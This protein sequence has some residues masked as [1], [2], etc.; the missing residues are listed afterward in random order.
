MPPALLQIAHGSRDPRHAATV[1]AL[2]REVRAQRPGLE[3]ATAYLDHCAPRLSQ[4]VARLDGPA[5]AVPLLLNRAY[6]AKHDIPAALRSAG[7]AGMP[8]ADVLGPAPLLLA[9]LERRLAQAGLDLAQRASTGVVLAAAGSSDPAADAAT[10]AL[11]ADWQRRGGWGAVAVAYASATGPR[12][13]DALA[14]LRA[15]GVQRTA[16][17]PYLLA[18]GV[19]PDRIAAAATEAGADVLAPVLGAA[20]EIARLLLARYEQAGM[21]AAIAAA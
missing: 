10:R 5:V 9:A 2:V 20:P 17:A 18:P 15:R 12:V 3:V 13:P 8:V 19:L 1:D 21:P 11:A 4:V 7:A 16:V 14:E 6:H